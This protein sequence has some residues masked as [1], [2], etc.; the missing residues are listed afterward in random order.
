MVGLEFPVGSTSEVGR[1]PFHPR[2][3]VGGPDVVPQLFDDWQGEDTKFGDVV[4]VRGQMKICR[5]LAKNGWY[6]EIVD[7]VSLCLGFQR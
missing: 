7:R 6:L 5:V 3:Q 4:G 2:G 1:R